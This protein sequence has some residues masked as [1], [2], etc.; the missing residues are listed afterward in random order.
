MKGEWEQVIPRFRWLHLNLQPVLTSSLPASAHTP[1]SGWLPYWAEKR[2]RDR[3]KRKEEGCCLVPLDFLGMDS[4]NKCC[5]ERLELWVLSSPPAPQM[6]SLCNKSPSTHLP[7]VYKSLSCPTGLSLNCVSW[8]VPEQS[9]C[10]PSNQATGTAS[11]YWL[12][13]RLWLSKQEHVNF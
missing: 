8:M 12:I 1:P 10:P 13:Q 4:C 9:L 2:E 3:R 7:D 6:A 11:G 5:L